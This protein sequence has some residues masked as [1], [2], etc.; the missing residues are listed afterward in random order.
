MTHQILPRLLRSYFQGT[1]SARS[2]VCLGIGEPSLSSGTCHRFNDVGSLSGF[3]FEPGKNT[4]T[5]RGKT[6]TSTTQDGRSFWLSN[7]WILSKTDCHIIHILQ[8]EC[9]KLFDGRE[10]PIKWLDMVGIAMMGQCPK[11]PIMAQIPQPIRRW[12]TSMSLVSPVN[13]RFHSLQSN[14]QDLYTDR[15][16][17]LVP[18]YQHKGFHRFSVVF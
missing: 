16:K 4:S 14:L 3:G 11:P 17:R 15:F 12:R 18:G 10:L 1:G 2:L 8:A 13:A 6:H 7:M 5:L 9:P